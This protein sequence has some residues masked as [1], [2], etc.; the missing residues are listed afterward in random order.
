MIWV[1]SD[2]FQSSPGGIKANGVTDDALGFFSLVLSY[3]K[4]AEN[5]QPD[6]S[7]K[8]LTTIMPR[9]NFVTMFKMVVN[10]LSGYEKG[11]LYDIVKVLACYK[12]DEDMEVM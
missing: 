8:T 4:A 9:T 11:T 1:Q 5:L 12:Y 2:F 10:G 3:A 6:D 7:P